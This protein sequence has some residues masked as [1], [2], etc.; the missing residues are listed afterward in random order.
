M[1]LKNSMAVV[2]G[3][4]SHQQIL[5]L[6]FPFEAFV[7]DL[8]NLVSLSSLCTSWLYVSSKKLQEVFL[9]PKKAQLNDKQYEYEYI[10]TRIDMSS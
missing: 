3:E 7:L 4:I 9:Q 6:S 2:L 5:F 8:A 1:F 10:E